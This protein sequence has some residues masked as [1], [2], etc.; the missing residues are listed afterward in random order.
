LDALIEA[1]RKA[2]DISADIEVQ[3]GVQPT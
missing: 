2:K 1:R 3:P